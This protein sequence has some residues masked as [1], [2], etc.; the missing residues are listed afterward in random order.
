MEEVRLDEGRA[1]RFA[2]S[3]QSIGGFDRLSWPSGRSY[4]AEDARRGNHDLTI[5]GHPGNVGS[6]FGAASSILREN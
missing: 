1:E 5:A 3:V 6:D 4:L 2:A